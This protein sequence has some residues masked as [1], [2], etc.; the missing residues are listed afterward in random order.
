M[1]KFEIVGLKE[2]ERSLKKLG[3]VPQKY[4][5]KASRKAMMIA[6]RSAKT[7]A[8]VDTGELKSGLKL[9]GEKSRFKGKKVYQVTFDRAKN[10]IF[11]KR[12]KD[13]EIVAY[14]PASQE[15][16][17]FARNGR[18]IPGYHFLEN[19]L[20]ENT[21]KIANTIISEMGKQIDEALKG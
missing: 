21:D 13:G 14:Y 8:P 16:G 20:V 17:F 10:D 5:T 12:N 2:L 1:S 15:Y 19:A 6:L 9:V 3:D 18:Y 11:Q 7:N 4:V